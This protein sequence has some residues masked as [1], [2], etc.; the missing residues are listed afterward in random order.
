MKTSPATYLQVAASAVALMLGWPGAVYAGANGSG[1]N[2]GQLP[3]DQIE[4]IIQIQGDIENGI[5]H[6]EVER[7]DIGDVQGPMGPVKPGGPNV[8]QVT[9]DGAFE[10]N[11]DIFFQPLGNGQ[12]FLNA[13]MALKEEEVNP[14]I[15]TLLKDGLIFQ[16][17]HQHLPMHPQVWF[18]HYRG[19]G[20]AIALAKAISDA[21]SVTSTPLPQ[22]PPPNPSTP[23]DPGKL[24]AILHADQVSVGDEGVVT[25]WV[26]RRDQVT[27][28]GVQVN[29]QA[30]ISTNIEFKPLGGSQA[31]V[32]PDF[33]MESSE[34]VPVVRLMLNQLGWYQGCLYNQETNEYEQLFFDHMLKVGDAYQLA[35]EIREGLNLTEAR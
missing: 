15:F 31:A 20:D 30:N 26:Y 24:A 16:A 14:F 2:T 7:N 8:P 21:I 1:G 33:S 25:L 13:D 19:I 27:I 11:G 3:V 12:A 6:L 5:L 34:I 35:R 17:F 9:F 10:I 29:P 22:A 23:L 28:D 18:V 4:K 32:V